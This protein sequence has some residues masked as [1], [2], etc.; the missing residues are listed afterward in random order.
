ME[1]PLNQIQLTYDQAQD[2]L[3]LSFNTQD[4]VEYRFWVTRHILKGFWGILKKIQQGKPLSNEQKTQDSKT[5]KDLI[6][7]E[8]QISTAKK[9]STRVTQSPLGDAPGLLSTITVTP[10]KAGN[11][12]FRL[13]DQRGVSID[14]NGDIFLVNIFIELIVKAMH[15]TDWGLQLD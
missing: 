5:A 13:E 1:S 11:I 10:N 12:H 4:F 2:R 15:Q 8:V 9:Y 7:E 3:A 14:L 6:K